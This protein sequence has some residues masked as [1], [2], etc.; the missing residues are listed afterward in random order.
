MH[1]VFFY[2]IATWHENRVSHQ[3][4][5]TIDWQKISL[6]VYSLVCETQRNWMFP[7]SLGYLDVNRRTRIYTYINMH[8][9]AA[10]WIDNYL[11]TDLCR[12]ETQSCER[13]I[14][15]QQSRM[16]CVMRRSSSSTVPSNSLTVTCPVKVERALTYD[17]T[18]SLR[19]RHRDEK[20]DECLSMSMKT[21][22]S[23]KKTKTG[24]WLIS[25]SKA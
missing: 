8:N 5:S 24:N 19:K 20:T 2:R 15:F 21:M 14:Q 10:K 12:A 16:T 13:D 22:D 17:A 7:L 11:V 23:A 4:F 25:Q 9:Y 1:N 6:R 18:S 3:L